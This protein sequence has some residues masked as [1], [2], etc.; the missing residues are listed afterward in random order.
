VERVESDC[1]SKWRVR[2]GRGSRRMGWRGSEVVVGRSRGSGVGV[3][4]GG[5]SGEGQKWLWVEVEGQ[6]LA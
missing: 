1:G 6:E 4:R 3:G 5:W 2:S